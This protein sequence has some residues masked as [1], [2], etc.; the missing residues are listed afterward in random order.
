VKAKGSGTAYRNDRRLNRR[1][2]SLASNALVNFVLTRVAGG[3]AI[4]GLG[5]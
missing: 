1:I 5:A 4:A 2:Q 3:D